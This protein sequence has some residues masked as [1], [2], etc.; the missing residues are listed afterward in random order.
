VSFARLQ[1]IVTYLLAAFGLFTLGFGGE[2][3]LAMLGVLAAGYTL[4]WWAEGPLL[5][6][7]WWS[8]GITMLLAVLL[9]AQFLRGLATGGWLGLAM[10][11]SGVLSIS[12]LANRRTAADYQQIAM[13]SF[14]QL[15]AATVLTT[16]LGYAGVFVAFAV[17]TPWVL[18]FAHLR[19]EIERNYP[20]E[21]DVDGGND[22]RR[23]LASRRIV[24]P[25]FLVWTAL[26]SLP[27]LAM[28]VALFAVFPRIG[29]GMLNLGS[30]RT[31]HVSGFG[32]NVELGGFGLIRNDPTVVVRVST[33]VKLDSM[34]ARRILRLR[35][36]A[37]DHYDGK[38]WTRS[39][40][41]SVRMAPLGEY[42]PLQRMEHEGDLTL[43][44]ILDRLDE[45]V[46]FVPA[47]AVGL[48]VPQRGLPR[49]PR[50]RMLIERAHGFDIRYTSSEELG[51]VYEAVISPRAA[52]HD[53]P[54]DRELDD[55]RYLQL[56]SGHERLYT[57]AR[58]LTANISEPAKKAQ[59]LLSYLR[60]E[61]RYAYSLQLADTRGKAPLE[62]FVFD[63]KRGHC[64]YFSS[65]LAIML[66]AVGIPARNVTGFAGGEFNTYGGYYAVR[67]ADAHSWVEA[68]LPG[69]GW[70][71]MDPTPA[72]RDAFSFSSVFDQARAMVDA[73]RA[74]WMTRVVSYDLRAQVRAV[75]NLRDFFRGISWPS[76]GRSPEGLPGGSRTKG[77]LPS[78]SWLLALV[79]LAAVALILWRRRPPSQSLSR[80][81]RRAQKL[82]RELEQLLARRGKARP[83][84]VTPEQHAR[85]LLEQG[86][87][88][89]PA[90]VKLTE[91]Y[92]RTRYGAE[93]LATSAELTQLLRDVKRAA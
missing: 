24:D 65:A 91:A 30:N 36:T 37:F 3:P 28:T 15:I 7:R 12:R 60:N 67:Q 85:V 44:L 71:M 32:N 6:K 86:F 19:R 93:P 50:E 63:N 47:G 82:Y 10:E 64:E 68:L 22:V 84:H 76:W 45:P 51:V 72:S 41:E 81:A 48:R 5:Q 80:D 9:A 46:L 49:G 21:S 90:V 88:A 87:V 29:L 31:E 33:P 73:A 25:S 89:A 13:L 40:G 70:V 54:V 83:V 43:R 77:G 14:I 27:M 61:K 75:R 59:R 57:L 52:E 62:A 1:K 35:G 20:A 4:S 42:Y 69:R 8:Q 78:A 17:V 92:V 66:R 18:T 16:D 11:F 38:T 56:P 2:I 39:E 34:T 26:L 53:V 74:Y 23:V 58:E 55:A 79:A